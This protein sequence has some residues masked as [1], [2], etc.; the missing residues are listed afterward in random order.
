[1]LSPEL[2]ARSLELGAEKKLKI[3]KKNSVSPFLTQPT[4]PI[5]AETMRQ[6]LTF[7]LFFVTLLLPQTKSSDLEICQANPDSSLIDAS[8]YQSEY[9]NNSLPSIVDTFQSWGGY[10]GSENLRKVVLILV[11]GTDGEEGEGSSFS[12]D[13]EEFQDYAKDL[14]VYAAPGIIMFVIFKRCES[15][16]GGPP[17]TW[18]IDTTLHQILHHV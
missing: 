13:N 7:I 17:Q 11:N 3:R 5:Q 18:S 4:H 12:P 16:I 1:M 8:S 9:F 6:T 14:I 10:S 2:G 15:K